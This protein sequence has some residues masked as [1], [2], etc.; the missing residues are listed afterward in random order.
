[1]ST[2][3]AVHFSPEISLSPVA[4]PLSQTQHIVLGFLFLQDVRLFARVR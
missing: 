4:C 2:L 3:W 1:M